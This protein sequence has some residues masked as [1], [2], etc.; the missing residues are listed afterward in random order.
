MKR[1]FLPLLVFAL[2]G[3]KTYNYYPP[4][5]NNAFFAN[6]GEVHV[7]G[8]LGASAII[9][10]NVKAGVGLTQHFNIIGT[11]GGGTSKSYKS[12]EGELGLGYNSNF[13]NTF[14][15]GIAAGYGLGKN[16][17]QDSGLSYKNFYGNFNKPFAQLTFGSAGKHLEAAF[18]IKFDY[19][20]YSGHQYAGNGAYSGYSPGT[21]FWEPYFTGSAGGEHVRLEYGTGFA[22]KNLS[23]IGE[24]FKVFPWQFNIGLYIIL[25]RKS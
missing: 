18:T 21:F 8:D 11:Y 6:G 4:S 25:N 10:P 17:D 12:N 3:C 20:N 19:M 2:A 23:Q 5:P 9:W 22:F 16:S 13:D 15:F 14:I 1:V 7:A 24:G